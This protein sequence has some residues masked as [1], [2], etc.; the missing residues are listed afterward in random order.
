MSRS[1]TI[2]WIANNGTFHEIRKSTSAYFPFLHSIFLAYPNNPKL[3]RIIHEINECEVYHLLRKMKCDKSIKLTI[4]VVSKYQWLFGS[5]HLSV[6]DE[7]PVSHIM[8]PYGCCGCV[9]PR[10]RHRAKW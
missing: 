1:A 10:R 4:K 8:S 5:S 3:A 9:M 7:V 2:K 6:G